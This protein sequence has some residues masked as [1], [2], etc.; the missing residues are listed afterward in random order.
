[1]MSFAYGGVP[2][3]HRGRVRIRFVEDP[4]SPLTSNCLAFTRDGRAF[5]VTAVA[6]RI[7]DGGEV[8]EQR[9]H[10]IAADIGLYALR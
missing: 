9:V 6:G 2:P 3:G 10:T 8:P 1:M 4:T 5:G 7:V